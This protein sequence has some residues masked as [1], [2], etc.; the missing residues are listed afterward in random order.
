MEFKLGEFT[1]VIERAGKREYK[2]VLLDPNRKPIYIGKLKP[3][4]WLDWHKHGSKIVEEL[5][6]RT[7]YSA[8]RVSGGLG[9][10]SG[11]IEMKGGRCLDPPA[12]ADATTLPPEQATSVE[13]LLGIVKGIRIVKQL[14][15]ETIYP[16]VLNVE[17]NGEKKELYLSDRSVFILGAVKSQ[18]LRT[19][20]RIPPA[21]FTISSDNWGKYVVNK[22]GE[23]D[24]IEIAEQEES[25]EKYVCQLITTDIC[26][27]RPTEDPKEAIIPGTYLWLEGKIWVPNTRIRDIL[28]TETLNVN[29]RKVREW[30]S[31]INAGESKVMRVGREFM[32]FWPFDPEKVGIGVEEIEKEL[33]EGS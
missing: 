14:D 28:R 1:A 24:K 27:S 6:P 23:D 16:V 3:K 2:L 7:G 5:S 11:Q 10:I 31:S 21:L 29:L 13:E 17:W 19:F 22:L 12:G 30:V 18:F 20:R 15:S 9:E 32:R 26:R 33:K 25:T 8:D 4:F